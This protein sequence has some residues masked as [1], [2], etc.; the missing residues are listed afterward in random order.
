MDS[1]C[2]IDQSPSAMRSRKTSRENGTALPQVSFFFCIRVITCAHCRTPSRSAKP[3]HAYHRSTT[4]N[5][6]RRSIRRTAVGTAS[7]AWHARRHD[8]GHAAT[9]HARNAGYA[10]AASRFSARRS[11]G[12]VSTS[13]ANDGRHVPRSAATVDAWLG[14]R[15]AASTST[16]T[17]VCTAAT[18]VDRNNVGTSTAASTA[19]DVWRRHANVGWFASATTATTNGA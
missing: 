18:T 6:R 14:Q 1:I 17:Y 15:D 10:T 16:A 8:D 7:T 13:T 3:A 12:C 5:V 4:S 9:W 11:D 2:A 19:T